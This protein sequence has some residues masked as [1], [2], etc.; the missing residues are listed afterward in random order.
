MNKGMNQKVDSV[1]EYVLDLKE[2]IGDQ[3]RNPPVYEIERG[4]L[5]EKVRSLRASDRKSENLAATALTAWI[6]ETLVNSTWNHKSRWI[7]K[8]L[9]VEIYGQRV[10]GVEFFINFREASELPSEQRDVVDVFFLCAVL[11]FRGCYGTATGSHVIENELPATFEE[12]VQRAR[13]RPIETSLGSNVDPAG[14]FSLDGKF[15]FL[16]ST[17]LNTAIG[18]ALAVT[19]WWTML[20]G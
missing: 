1:F 4:N 12:W 13:P 2:R 15:R 19:L 3:T 6:D 11:G 7:D 18:L 5:L 17:V 14:A 20:S 10:A 16:A 8:S 9:W